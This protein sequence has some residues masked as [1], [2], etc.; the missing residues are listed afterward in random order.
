MYTEAI[1]LHI[2]NNSSNDT[3]SLFNTYAGDTT[4]EE[5]DFS[6]SPSYQYCSNYYR[7]AH[8]NYTTTASIH[9]N[10]ENNS[11][12]MTD[13]D[14][15]NYNNALSDYS[16]NGS[17][18]TYKDELLQISNTDLEE[19][20]YGN[21]SSED[22]SFDFSSPNE[23]NNLVHTQPIHLINTNNILNDTIQYDDFLQNYSCIENNNGC[24]NNGYNNNGCNNNSNNYGSNSNN[25]NN[26][27]QTEIRFKQQG[28]QDATLNQRPTYDSGSSSLSSIFS[29]TS[30]KS[31]SFL[32]QE[33]E[34][35]KKS[36]NSYKFTPVQETYS[37]QGYNYSQPRRYQNYMPKVQYRNTETSV[38]IEK[39][40]STDQNEFI[41]QDIHYYMPPTE[42]SAHDS[43]YSSTD[44]F[45]PNK[46]TNS[47]KPKNFSVRNLVTS[48]EDKFTSQITKKLSRYAKDQIYF[49]KVRF[50]EISY[51]FSKTYF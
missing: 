42:H 28:S 35:T 51:R 7:N 13:T 32:T 25:H 6:F 27:Q 10:V 41:V 11:S 31:N 17:P 21:Y 36:H 30:E 33:N 5:L 39:S 45:Y 2:N 3:N 26:Y 8:S 48:E 46:S 16:M 22:L 20:N 47:H 29:N 15:I 12:N 4:M 49:D 1:P 23:F 40:L 9:N 37:T 50:Q 24:N 14:F 18:Q 38:I 34:S 43:F 44:V 19:H